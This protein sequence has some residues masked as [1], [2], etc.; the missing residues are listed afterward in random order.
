MFRFRRPAAE[1]SA[2]DTS[3]CVSRRVVLGGLASLAVLFAAPSLAVADTP[4][5]KP[6]PF[7]T[8]APTPEVRD[9][10]GAIAQPTPY[11]VQAS[12][13][14]SEDYFL[15]AD[16]LVGP[17][18]KVVPFVNHLNGG[19]IEAVVMTEAT[20]RLSHVHQDPTT[21]S[22]WTISNIPMSISS[23]TDVAVAA[24]PQG[25]FVLA[26][27]P[28][29]NGQ[30]YSAISWLTDATT[31]ATG[32]QL[33]PG[34]PVGMLRGGVSPDQTP[35]FYGWVLNTVKSGKTTYDNYDFVTWICGPSGVASMRSILSLQ[36]PATEQVT[37]QDA[38][39]QYDV[40]DTGSDVH[41]VAAV[42]LDVG[43]DGAD[44]QELS[45][46]PQ[47]GSGFTTSASLYEAGGVSTLLWA[48]TPAPGAWELLTQQ[49]NGDIT[50]VDQTGTQ[51][52]LY[53]AAAT[54]GDGAVAPWLLD[55]AYTF[56]VLENGLASVM[57]QASAG[58]PFTLPI[59]LIDGVETIY[60]VLS[61]PAQATLFAV[62]ADT[63]LNVL[64][65]DP[66][67]GW[68]QHQVHQENATMQEVRSYRAKITV[69]DA[70]GVPVGVG[71]AQIGTDRLVGM[72]QATGNTIIEP[73]SPVTVTADASGSF[74]VSI[75]AEDLDCATLTVQALD[76]NGNASG[77]PFVV[78]PHIDV[79]RFLAGQAS[80]S[81]TGM[82]TGSA[83]QSAQTSAGSNL[84][85]G[86]GGSSGA[87]AVAGAI[88]HVGTLGL[89]FQPSSPT[90]V[91]AATFDLTGSAPAFQTSTDP[92]A[93]SIDTAQLNAKRRRAA[94]H[95][96]KRHRRPHGHQVGEVG[97]ISD[98]WNSVKSDAESA[99]HGLR[100][101]V[102][103]FKKMVT[104][105]SAEAKQWTINLIVDIGDGLDNLMTYVVDDVRSAVHAISSF[106]HA[107]GADIVDGIDW[108][109]HHVLE[110]LAEAEANAKII[111]GWFSSAIGTAATP[112]PFM[113]MADGL[114]VDTDDFFT[115]LATNAHNAITDIETA[116]EDV[117][118]GSAA[119]LPAPTT[120]TGSN[121]ADLILK[122]AGEFAKFLSHCSGSWLLDKIMHH[123][124]SDDPG[125]AAVADFG[126]AI[127]QLATDFVDALTL[128]DSIGQLMQT[129]AQQLFPSTSSFGQT[130]MTAWF[131]AV[132][133]TVDDAVQL[134]QA[135]ADTV[136]DAMKLALQSMLDT[137]SYEIQILSGMWQYTL[138]GQIFKA[139]GIDPT[140]SVSHLMGL[141]VAYPATLING[142]QGGGPLFPT[143]SSSSAA[144]RRTRALKKLGLRGRGP[145]GRRLGAGN[146]GWETG[147]GIS[148]AVV[149]GIWGLN[150]IIVDL[151]TGTEGDGTARQAPSFCA[152]ID[153]FAPVVLTILQWPSAKGPGGATMYPFYGGIDTSSKEWPMLPWIIASGIMPSL[154]GL[155]EQREPAGSGG[156]EAAPHGVDDPLKDYYSPIV[157]MVSGIV[158]TVLGTAYNVKTSAGGSAIA[159]GVLG[160]LSYMLAVLAQKYVNESAED[161]PLLI[162]TVVDA[163]GN[164]GAA[165]CIAEA[166]SLP[167]K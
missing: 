155:L 24:S 42:L 162:K 84:F 37:I 52:Y 133:N 82:L 127:N 139:A 41:G 154:M 91:Q 99:F 18:D 3:P 165:I 36:Y 29:F 11:Y 40:N 146:D 88:S 110:L 63:T 135:I 120:D 121:D 8:P 74:S 116:V 61:D 69:L 32:T 35:Y 46:Y 79:A 75:P 57:S 114:S 71:Q 38:I 23:V 96:S 33:G 136:I 13:E 150:D 51:T 143:T 85:A 122:D 112:G 27:A 102:L 81:D 115:D 108:L 31:W 95:L 53:A 92:N 17:D 98:W 128:A 134:L 157:Q 25:V 113:T 105:W 126:P 163:A 47:S 2:P 147:L 148:A 117:T 72:W 118:F 7:G 78:T 107:L 14:L 1:D 166:T 56:T 109:K 43:A 76:G 89:G 4:K 66:T 124:P 44:G 65:K 9:A 45:L 159:G 39:L 49:V 167:P 80:L 106:F 55:G 160:N 90:D 48:N 6:T 100:R 62:F 156:N 86:L 12:C 28:V 129:S 119:P 64:T 111:Q 140:L 93:F 144:A 158:N 123:L 132:D 77:E 73:G 58:G 103:K 67:A 149:Q 152:W 87:T 60:S 130:S 59:P 15:T 141:V 161:V 50:F 125:P 19:A 70:N 22:G 68:T 131:G 153:I 16:V 20:G 138:I 30:M 164:I 97:G 151:Q 101:G 142:L 104:S 54:V 26:F 21:T 137:L 5:P 145:K 34:S 94:R 10:N 83:L